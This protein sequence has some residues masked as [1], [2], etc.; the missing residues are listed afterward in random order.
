MNDATREMDEVEMRGIGPRR[1][2]P[3]HPA[4]EVAVVW[5]GGVDGSSS[6]V[7]LGDGAGGGDG[8]G[9]IKGRIRR[10]PRI[11]RALYKTGHVLLAR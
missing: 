9:V 10:P 5:G 2:C 3:L 1:R 4:A 8:V 7:F 11:I 6:F